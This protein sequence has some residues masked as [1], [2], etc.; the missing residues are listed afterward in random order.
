MRAI[1]SKDTL[2][3]IFLRKALHANGFRFRLNVKKLSGSP[4]IVLPK[5]N[6]VIFVHGCFWHGH[7]CHLFKMPQT[8]TEFW[9]KKINDNIRRDLV[10]KDN[11]LKTGWRIAIVWECAL[12]GKQKLSYDKLI[13]NLSMWLINSQAQTLELEGS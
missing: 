13:D 8:R 9:Q 1:R 5:Y 3:E 4:D 2:P 10:T 7:H 11:L 6:A 12:K